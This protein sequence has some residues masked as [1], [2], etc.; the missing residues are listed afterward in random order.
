MKYTA[1]L[2]DH[3]KSVARSVTPRKRL[4]IC[5]STLLVATKRKDI[6]PLAD[7]RVI[8]ILFTSTSCGE[9]LLAS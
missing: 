2:T 6:H 8:A 9:E 5:Q 4:L 1:G 3:E 7:E